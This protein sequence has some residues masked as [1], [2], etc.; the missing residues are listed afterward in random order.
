MNGG[1]NI[2]VNDDL[3]KGEGSTDG[4][5]LQCQRGGCSEEAVHDVIGIGS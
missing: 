5:C 3:E 2:S 4:V 1:A